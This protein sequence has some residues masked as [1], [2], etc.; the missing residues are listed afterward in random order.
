[1]TDDDC[2]AVRKRNHTLVD[3]LPPDRVFEYFADLSAVPRGSGDTAR[4]GAFLEAFARKNNLAAMRDAT[5]N[6]I[7]RKPAQHSASPHGVILQAHMDMVCIK[8]EESAHD[9]TADPIE[10]VLN[11]D[12]LSANNTTLGGD[13]GIGVAIAMAVLTNT[14]IAHP[15]LEALFT[16]DEE[17][18]MRGAENV[19]PAM[20][21]GEV[22]INLDA[23]DLNT[24]Y[25]SSAAGVR[26]ELHLPLD[27]GSGEKSPFFRRVAIEGLKGGHSGVEINQARANAYVLLARVLHAAAKEYPDFALHTFGPGNSNGKDNAIPASAEAVVGLSSKE[28][29]AGLA[30]MAKTWTGI[31][32]NEF[33]SSDPEC[34]IT[35]ETASEPGGAS[36]AL[37]NEG[38]DTLV[39]VVTLLPLGV[40]R[41]IQTDA[42]LDGKLAYSD[43]LVET[44]C[45]MGIASLSGGMA[46]LTLLARGSTESVLD[47]M[48][49]RVAGLAALA[50]GTLPVTSTTRGWEM[51]AHL[52]RVQE[53]FAAQ[54]LTCLGVHAGL[55]CG[56]LVDSFKKAGRTLDAISI[57]PD[58][59][60]VH[61]PKERLFCHSTVRLWEQLTA[62]LARL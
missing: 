38:R 13:D 59:K 36:P 46:K 56:C 19:D 4:A 21:E 31:F 60:D 58:V 15:P 2:A 16:V 27:I 40:F 43:L 8:T 17:T 51:P 28:A 3:A 6:V 26:A 32:R 55:E 9:F 7:I 57:G 22:L 54:G 30:A 34:T 35:V 41:F 53:L 52:N 5:G 23:E 39:R 18:S 20:L 25:I 48:M 62:V 33:R 12:E 37:T 47:D 61:T 29:A 1:M 45:N 11:G 14:E 10:L 50:G 24:A 49:Q 44:S 42:L